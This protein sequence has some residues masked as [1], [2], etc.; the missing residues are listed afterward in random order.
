MQTFAHNIIVYSK[1]QFCDR[2]EMPKHRTQMRICCLTKLHWQHF[3]CALC[4]ADMVL[5]QSALCFLHIGWASALCSGAMHAHGAYSSSTVIQC[6]CQ[7]G[8]PVRD[9]LQT[10]FNVQLFLLI[11]TAFVTKEWSLSWAFHTEG[12]HCSQ[13]AVVGF[14]AAMSLIKTIL[15][16]SVL[17]TRKLLYVQGACGS[18]TGIWY[19]HV[20]LNMIT[21]RPASVYVLLQ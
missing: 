4:L 21:N 7:R 13:E 12:W 1:S 15:T 14:P 5:A 11:M 6:E 2:S 16:L 3:V 19:W 20:A 10:L 18:S 17:I 8:A 9:H